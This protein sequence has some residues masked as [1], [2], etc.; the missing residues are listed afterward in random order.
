MPRTCRHG[1]QIKARMRSAASCCSVFSIRSKLGQRSIRATSL[2]VKASVW[3]G[4]RGERRAP[5]GARSS[6][7]LRCMWAGSTES[8]EP[9]VGC[10]V[11]YRRS[12]QLGERARHAPRS[13]AS[14]S[15]RSTLRPATWRRLPCPR[16]SARCMCSWIRC[17]RRTRARRGSHLN[18]VLAQISAA[19]QWRARSPGASTLRFMTWM[20][21]ETPMTA[22]NDDKARLAFPHIS[23]VTPFEFGEVA[24][25]R[26]VPERRLLRELTFKHLLRAGR[27]NWVK[28]QASV[29]GFGP[30]TVERCW[31]DVGQAWPKAGQYCVSPKIANLPRNM[32]H[33]LQ[34]AL[35]EK[36]HL[37]H[38]A[39][40]SSQGARP[41]CDELGRQETDQRGDRFRALRRFMGR[42]ACGM[43]DHGTRR[44]LYAVVFR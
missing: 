41:C 19:S 11:G 18:A 24:E 8:G 35:G 25:T 43:H 14:V 38:C 28:S 30:T 20:A 5:R 3:P 34:N 36:G 44:Q 2:G 17:K 13:P 7:C 10:V 4:S 9:C 27:P 26:K 21:F 6:A 33:P 16:F 40:L 31:S 15:A 22:E 39:H 1:G 42:P 32:A 23:E 12:I 29:A 37:S